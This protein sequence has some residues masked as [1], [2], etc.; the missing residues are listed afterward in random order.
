MGGG[1]DPRK[2]AI[3]GEGRRVKL[4]EFSTGERKR[5]ARWGDSEGKPILGK[6]MQYDE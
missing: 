5:L 3:K 1:A 2:H 6:Y 4:R